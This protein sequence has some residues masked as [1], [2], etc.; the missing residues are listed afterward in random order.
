MLNI[1]LPKSIE[2]QIE[3]DIIELSDLLQLAS[4]EDLETPHR[5][6]F[7][8]IMIVIEGEGIQYIDFK[9]YEYS[10]GT[11]FFV[12]KHQ[13]LSFKMN[14]HLKCFFLEF[15]DNFLNKLTNNI[16]YDIFDYTKYPVNM[17]LSDSYFNDIITN[18]KLLTEQ[19]KIPVDDFKEL[20][21]QS[22]LKSL[23]LQLTRKRV[24]ESLPHFSKNQKLYSDFIHLVHSSHTYTDQVKEYAKKLN[25]SV[26]TLSNLLHKYTD[27]STKAYLDEFLLLEIKRYLLDNTLTLQE[28]SNHLK[29]DEP[30]NLVKF[31]KRLENQTPT[32][33]RQKVGV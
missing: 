11:I 15:T 24:L 31:F 28:I 1:P 8:L 20:I 17:Q 7:N 4:W 32:E 12:K 21:L 23:L 6:D 9:S 3:F 19:L 18:T 26:R 13:A 22:L 27:K 10:K 33:F 2:N 25:I 16:I 29:F 5:L 30:T 14:P